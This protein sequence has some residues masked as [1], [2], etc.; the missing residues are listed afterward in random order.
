MKREEGQ[1]KRERWQRVCDKNRF[2]L[3][4]TELERANN[5][6]IMPFYISLP[7]DKIDEY[8]KYW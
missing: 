8:I 7:Q 4:L 6:E 2:E 5:R 3:N 1:C